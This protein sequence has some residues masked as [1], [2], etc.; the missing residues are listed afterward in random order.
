MSETSWPRDYFKDATNIEPEPVCVG[1]S[2]QD[3]PAIT[4]LFDIARAI[5][6]GATIPPDAD[7]LRMIAKYFRRVCNTLDEIAAEAMEDAPPP[8]HVA[9]PRPV[10][11]AI[12]GGRA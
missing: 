1:F 7:E 12:Q 2:T 11:I 5:D 6:T 8:V 10:L 3:D 4:A 9:P